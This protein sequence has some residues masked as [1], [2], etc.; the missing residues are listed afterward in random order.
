VPNSSKGKG[1]TGSGICAMTL[2]N[3]PAADEWTRQRWPSMTRF[4]VSDS[5]LMF[6]SMPKDLLLAKAHADSSSSSGSVKKLVLS[7]TDCQ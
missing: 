2:P 3:L 7:E 5:D 4:T 6:Q 1:D